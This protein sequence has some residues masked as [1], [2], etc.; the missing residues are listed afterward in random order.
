VIC[1]QLM[2][3][4]LGKVVEYVAQ[5]FIHV[6]KLTRLLVSSLKHSGTS[7][8]AF[9]M[10]PANACKSPSLLLSSMS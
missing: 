3:N 10:L 9:V 4:E 1:I 8:L 6:I 5:M 7:T 2:K